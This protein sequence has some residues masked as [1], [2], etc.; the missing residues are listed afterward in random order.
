MHAG[1]A[2]LK[3]RNYSYSSAVQQLIHLAS[4]WGGVVT[5]HVHNAHWICRHK[6]KE[7]GNVV[8]SKRFLVGMGVG[9]T[10]TTR[11]GY[12]VPVV[13]AQCETPAY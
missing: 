10:I 11:Y 9:K 7:V 1:Q 3:P 4:N 13:T 5:N 8:I 12:M 2:K 6:E